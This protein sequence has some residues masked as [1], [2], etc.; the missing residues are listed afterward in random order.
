MCIIELLGSAYDSRGAARRGDIFAQADGTS[1]SRAL[2]GS[3]PVIVVKGST[4]ANGTHGDQ[5]PMV[6]LFCL[7]KES[8][9][10][11]DPPAPS[12]A[13]VLGGLCSLQELQKQCPVVF[14]CAPSV[15]ARRADDTPSSRVHAAFCI[16]SKCAGS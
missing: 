10:G 8:A 7:R 13:C 2:L 14:L 1:D 15:R 16:V 9:R 3:Y 12:A 6:L 11:L 5:Y 4:T